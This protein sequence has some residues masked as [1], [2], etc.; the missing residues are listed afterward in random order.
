[1]SPVTAPAVAEAY[2][3]HGGAVLMTA[4]SVCGPSM[5]EGVTEQV[6]LQLWRHPEDLEPSRGTL[7]ASLVVLAHG[8]ALE[9]VHAEIRRRTRQQG[10]DV[11]SDATVRDTG[12]TALFGTAAVTRIVRAVSHLPPRERDA[13]VLAFFGKCGSRQTAKALGQPEGLVR[14]RIRAGLRRLSVVLAAPSE[15]VRG[16]DGP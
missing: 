5:A 16:S 2:R 10:R 12:D 13:L 4:R 15:P 6:F 3:Q 14:S 1:M 9:A 8:K 11:A 7:R